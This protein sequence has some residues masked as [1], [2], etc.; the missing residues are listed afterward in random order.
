MLELAE[1]ANLTAVSDGE[2]RHD[3]VVREQDNLRAALDWAL[4]DGQVELGLRLAIALENFWAVASAVEGTR[5]VSAFLERAGDDLSPELRGDALRVCAGTTYILGDYE[6]G[7]QYIEQSLDEYRKLGDERR[8]GHML[9]RLAVEANRTG[10]HRRAR[11][12]ATESLEL[13]RRAGHRRSEPQALA[14]LA[15]V[16]FGEGRHERGMELLERAAT[17]ARE[18]GF[19][20]WLAGTTGELAFQALALGR[21]ADAARWTRETLLLARAMADRRRLVFGLALAAGVAAQQHDPALAGRLWG[22]I[23][24]EEQ[25][26]RV[27]QWEDY[28]HEFEAHVEPAWGADFE[29]GREEGRRLTLD[30]AVAAALGEVDA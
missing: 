6:V 18:I 3:I 9:L 27:G 25:R 26:G 4:A 24:G 8:I 22:A 13:G 2:Q 15:Y 14:T 7:L 23:E 29:R 10:D 30:Q 12:L 21:L 28:R 19:T 16:E 11:E 1:S 5:R 20:W 17:L